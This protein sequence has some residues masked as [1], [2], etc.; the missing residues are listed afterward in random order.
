MSGQNN[1]DSHRK[2]VGQWLSEDYEWRIPVYQRHYAWNPE[3]EFG[4][5]QL[6]W[7]TVHEQAKKRLNGQKVDPHYFGAI[8]VEYKEGSAQSIQKYDV[9]DGQQ[10]LTTLNVALFAVISA[11]S[12]LGYRAEARDK[13]EKYIFNDPTPES[14]EKPKLVPTNFDRAQF[15][16]LLS[17]AFE[18]SRAPKDDSDQAK[19]SK[20]VQSCNFFKE[21]FKTFIKNNISM[22]N[23]VVIDMLI[24][25]ILEG[26]ELVL[27]QLKE[28]DE[29]QIV[30]ESLNNTALPLTTF[31]LIRNNIF[32]RAD[33]ESPGNDVDLFN[34]PEWQQFED[35]FWEETPGRSNKISHIESYIARMLMAKTQRDFLL[36]RNS[37]FKE[38]KK[39]A[40]DEAAS[41]LNTGAE[42]KTISEYVD[43]YKYLV[44]KSKTNPLGDEFDFGYFMLATCKS[45]DFYPVIF[46]IAKCDSSVQDKQNMLYLLEI[47]VIRR[48]LCDWTSGNYN[49]QASRICK[50]FGHKPSYEKLAEHLNDS[51][52]SETRKF[53]SNEKISSACLN[54][55]FN[56][57]D[58]KKY[59][60]H[61]ILHHTAAKMDDIPASSKLVIDHI[62]PKAW[63]ATAGWVDDFERADKSEHEALK[64]FAKDNVD[65]KIQTIGNLTPL[66]KGIN[67]KK[68]DGWTS[69]AGTKYRLAKCDLKMTRQL[70]DKDKWGVDEIDER[71]KELAAIICDIW[72][73]DIK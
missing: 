24:E 73:R 43:V 37:I 2:T 52:E 12:G 66:S 28:T 39:F 7:E 40:A 18:V 10:R 34:S 60:F 61:R 25:T 30:F 70:A 38:Y 59:I 48:H 69:T 71:S 33:K 17:S 13:L 15:R 50:V 53:P 31:D 47:Y 62:M 16:N 55:N 68:S 32:Y 72:P 5:T 57:S 51:Q 46:M 29:A 4:P 3:Q 63:R 45:M 11:A 1:N 49:K 44:G 6:F 35:T 64:E 27:I 56:K 42:T 23:A 19:K 41:G 67:L 20:I 8:L 22:G 9:V 21:K 14:C 65:I 36:N 26:F 58:L 54:N